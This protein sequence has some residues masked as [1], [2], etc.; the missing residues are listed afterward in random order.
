M[1]TLEAVEMLSVEADET[2]VSEAVEML[3]VEADETYVSEEFVLGLF[4]AL[5]LFLQV[6]ETEDTADMKALDAD[7]EIVDVVAVG[8]DMHA[9]KGF[10]EL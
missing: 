5:V 2:Y 3:S 6:V 1:V 8:H 9:E 4:V 10:E 7:V